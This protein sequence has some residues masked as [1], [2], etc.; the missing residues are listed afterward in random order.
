MKRIPKM[1]SN[2]HT[3]TTFCDG[4]N[5]PEQMVKKAIEK[6]FVSLGFSGHAYTAFEL[7]SCMKDEQGYIDEISRLK[8]AYEGQI[9]IYLGTEEDAFAPVDRS[10]YEYIIGSS[11][12][13]RHGG[14]ILPLAYLQRIGAGLAA[15]T[16]SDDLG[17]FI[18]GHGRAA[19]G[20][21]GRG[22]VI[23]VLG[24]AQ[25]CGVIRGDDDDPVADFQIIDIAYQ[26]GGLGVRSRR[27]DGRN[28]GQN[29]GKYQ[30]QRKN[31]F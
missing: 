14:K 7:T 30:R 10:K 20:N 17:A 1:L 23:G 2:L 21:S 15:L 29:H 16:Q 22:A 12:F 19:F 13:L 5:A 31:P 25:R 4:I 27:R 6:G 3:H 26:L 9:E 28:H 18:E 8:K 24:G 11:H